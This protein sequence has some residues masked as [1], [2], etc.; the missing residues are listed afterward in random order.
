LPDLLVKGGPTV[1]IHITGDAV[2]LEIGDRLVAVARFGGH[3][4]VGNGAWVV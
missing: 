1:G 2:T 3:A 4:V